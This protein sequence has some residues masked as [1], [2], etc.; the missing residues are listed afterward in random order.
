MAKFDYGRL[1]DTFTRLIDRFSEVDI[2][3]TR[4][5]GFTVVDGVDVP[6]V[7]VVTPVPAIVNPYNESQINN[8][9]ILTGDLQLYINHKFKPLADDTFTVDGKDYKV[10]SPQTYQPSLTTLGYRVQVRK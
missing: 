4:V 8:T 10:V 9:T 3:I 5:T 6:G 2:N 1:Q 7:P